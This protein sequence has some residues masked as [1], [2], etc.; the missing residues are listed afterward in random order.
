MRENGASCEKIVRWV[1]SVGLVLGVKVL[2]A[3]MVLGRF[4]YQGLRLIVW[5]FKVF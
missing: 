5:I 3:E 2:V 4:G 1:R